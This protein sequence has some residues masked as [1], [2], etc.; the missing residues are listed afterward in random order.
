MIKANVVV[1]FPKWKKK[2]KNP[3][4]YIQMKIR[5]LNKIYSFVNKKQEFSILLTNKSKMKNLNY[6]FRKKN[7]STNVLSFPS[8]N[9]LGNDNYI[10]DIAIGFEF[11]NKKLEISNFRYEFDK[12]WI[13]GYLHL[14]G[15]D[16]KK[17]KDYKKMIKKEKLLFKNLNK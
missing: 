2:I 3:E 5:K 10:G 1:D 14:I 16:H 11:L 17:I 15:Y 12:L 7:K 9:T 6:K 13:H 4:K 8:N